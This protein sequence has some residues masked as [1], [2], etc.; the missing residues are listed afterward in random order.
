MEDQQKVI[1]YCY[2]IASVSFCISA[3]IN[4]FSNDTSFLTMV[5]LCLGAT[6]LCLAST[7]KKDKSGK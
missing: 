5:H 3:V 2:L 4:F 7:S 1:Y 6:F